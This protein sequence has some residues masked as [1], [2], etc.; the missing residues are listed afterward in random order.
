MANYAQMN[1]GKYHLGYRFP[2][3]VLI[4]KLNMHAENEHRLELKFKHSVVVN[5]TVYVGNVQAFSRRNGTIK[6]EGDSMYKSVV[7]EFDTF[8]DYNKIEA[9]VSDGEEI[10]ALSEYNDKI[11]QF[12]QNTLYIINVANQ[13]EILEG[14]HSHKGVNNP[15]AVCKTDY[16]IAWVNHHGCYL[17]DGRTVHNLLE[18]DGL[19][20][21]KESIWSTFL[22]N[23]SYNPMIGYFPQKRQLIIVDDQTTSGVGACYIYDMVTTSWIKSSN[24]KFTSATLSNFIND[25]NGDLVHATSALPKKW[26]DSSSTTDGLILKTK[27]IDFGQPSVRKKVYKIYITYKITSAATN[28]Q[29][30]YDSDGRTVFDKTFQDGDNFASNELANAGGGQWVQATLKPSTSSDANNIY[31]FALKFTTDGTVPS[32]FK[33]NDITFVYRIKNP[34]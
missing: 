31:S 17:Y 26:S 1:P 9:A 8:A 34:R 22:N 12:K 32:T 14:T 10:T 30:H 19:R 15:A 25:W 33:I 5:R 21:I 11:L 29:V 2:T 6:V 18:K 24:A 3:P 20:K 23:G 7:N 13:I 16:G 4:E 27:D 28:V